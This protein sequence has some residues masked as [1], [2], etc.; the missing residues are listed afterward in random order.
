M[1]RVCLDVELGQ[2][3]RKGFHA[4]APRFSRNHASII[5]YKRAEVVIKDV[6]GCDTL[7]LRWRSDAE[8]DNDHD[9]DFED[10]AQA[11]V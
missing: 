5:T 11:R 4:W 3:K 7:R 6:K 2:V 1:K 8:R 10:D 9:F